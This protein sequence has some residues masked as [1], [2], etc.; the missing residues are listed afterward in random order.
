MESEDHKQ[1]RVTVQRTAQWR[2]DFA[3]AMALAA[4]E[5][6]YAGG[7]GEFLADDAEK[8]AKGFADRMAEIRAAWAHEDEGVIEPPFATPADSIAGELPGT[9]PGNPGDAF[10][11][12]PPFNPYT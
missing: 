6:F 8:V 10:A 11:R 12:R 1:W 2:E 3:Q 9:V 4:V 5:G 7:G